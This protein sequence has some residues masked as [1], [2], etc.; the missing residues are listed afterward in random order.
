MN[1]NIK[2]VDEMTIDELIGQVI[3]VGIPG[4]KLDD[5]YREFIKE[6]KIGNFIL[7][8]RN[9]DNTKQ[10]KSLMSE[11]YDYTNKITGSFPLVSIDQEGGMVVRLFKDVTF[12]ASPLTTSATLIK[13]AA[14]K[15]GYIIGKDMLKIGINLNL[16]PCL[17]INEGLS[18]P[19]VNVRGYGATKENV[20]QK[21]KSFVK[22]IQ[23]SGALSCIKHFPGAGSST[24][25]SHLELPIIEDSKESL[26]NYNMYPFMH[27]LESDAVMTS[28]CLYKSFD[29]LPSTLSNVLL[30]DVLRK[31]IGFEGIIISDGMEMKAIADFYGIGEGCVMALNAGCDILLLCH[32]YNEQKEAFIHVRKAV[33]EGRLSID[34]LKDKVRRI[35][36]SKEKVRI[37]LTKYFNSEEYIV[38]QEEHDLMQE[39]VDNSYTLIKGKKPYI[40]SDTLVILSRVKV[41]SIA[42][43]EFNERN[44]TKVIKQNFPN[45]EVIEFCNDPN[46]LDQ[47][48]EKIKNHKHILVYSYDAYKDNVQKDV[49]N[50]LLL[51]DKE[52]NIISIKGPIDQS[53]FKNLKNYACLYEYTPNS[54]R[55]II[56]QLKNEIELNGKL[57]E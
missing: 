44:L 4:L 37:G 43:D 45:N 29:E 23:T 10:M 50:Y 8:S 40:S 20:L 38:N 52:V 27:I 5:L 3:M 28:H 54:I 7:F 26:L 48:K 24:K 12:P 36:Q 55:T 25:D 9:Y 46:F 30:T 42:E 51:T 34:K 57:P 22:G 19:L 17:E 2:P 35:N 53:Y 33:E 14:Y 18:N 13:D 32:E 21:A 56:K 6:Y 39:I 49:I 41:A 15:T 47:I 16:A 1:Y 31:Q 11:L